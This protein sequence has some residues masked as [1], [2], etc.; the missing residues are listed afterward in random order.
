M[1]RV[2]T[3]LRT[4][5][6][7]GLDLIIWIERIKDLLVFHPP[8]LSNQNK[9]ALFS[10]KVPLTHAACS[11]DDSKLAPNGFELRWLAGWVARRFNPE[12]LGSRRAD[13]RRRS[14]SFTL[15]RSHLFSIMS[16]STTQPAKRSDGPTTT[17]CHN[18]RF[19]FFFSGVQNVTWKNQRRGF[20]AYFPRIRSFEFTFSP[21]AHFSHYFGK[22]RSH[23]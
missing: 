2:C 7:W 3:V 22:Q 10:Q 23:M 13:H 4:Y 6:L 1:S 11:W 18:F 21:L 15:A 14:G 17:K 12:A 8:H 19:S 9:R 5:I 20:L 16:R